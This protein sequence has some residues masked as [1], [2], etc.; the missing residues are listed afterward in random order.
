MARP[1]VTQSQNARAGAELRRWRQAGKLSLVDLGAKLATVL[2][3]R[4]PDG[5]LIAKWERGASAP[6]D[7]Y[8]TALAQIGA[9][10][11]G[12]R[13]A[14]KGGDLVVSPPAPPVD[15]QAIAIDEAQ[16][17]V[18][19]MLGEGRPLA[20]VYAVASR[21]LA[22]TL[23]GGLSPDRQRAWQ[24]LVRTLG[25]GADA[26]G[27]VPPLEKHPD[28]ARVI[29]RVLNVLDRYPGAAQAL[30]EELRGEEPKSEPRARRAA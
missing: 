27:K 14:G 24:M 3:G 23:G 12:W 26:A 13:T 5:S 8:F 9:P 11:D 1:D 4:T 17:E 22:L 29:E 2:D 6:G 30:L 7:A 16:V 28:W 20:E 19:K 15:P 25:L 18:Q 10:V 21:A